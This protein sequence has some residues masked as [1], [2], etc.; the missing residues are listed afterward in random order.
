MLREKNPIPCILKIGVQQIDKFEK[1][2]QILTGKF[3]YKQYFPHES[4]RD[5]QIQAIDFILDAFINRNKKYVACAAGTG[6][7]KSAIAI[8]VMRYLN[9]K[10]THSEDYERGSY[11]LTTQKILQEQYMK[12]FGAPCG[13]LVS[14]KKCGIN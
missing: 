5:E 14:I 3:D 10:L 4:I 1:L 7:G 9:D 2:E 13:N 8:T 6:V 12:D 11:V